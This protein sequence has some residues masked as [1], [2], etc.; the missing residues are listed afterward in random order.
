MRA[1]L[2]ISITGYEDGRPISGRIMARVDSLT[3]A[4]LIDYYCLQPDGQ[5]QYRPVKKRYKGGSN[6]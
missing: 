3:N 4:N 5:I 6:Q 2:E 1:G